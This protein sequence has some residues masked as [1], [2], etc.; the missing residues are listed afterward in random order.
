[1]VGLAL[2]PNGSLLRMS[3]ELREKATGISSVFSP[4][5]SKAF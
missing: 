4:T 1:M 3:S 2:K 5:L